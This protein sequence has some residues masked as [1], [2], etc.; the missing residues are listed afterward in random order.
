L[1]GHYIGTAEVESAL[2][3][4]KSVEKAA[5]IGKPDPV[6][7]NSIKAFVILRVGNQLN[8]RLRQDLFHHVRTTPGPI[9]IPPEIE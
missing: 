1:P 9:A 3:S 5:V 6:K 8:D 2:V 4:H 7:G